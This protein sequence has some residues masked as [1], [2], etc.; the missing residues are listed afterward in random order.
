VHNSY[1]Q[2]G[3]EDAVVDAETA[4][5]R[6]NG[7][8]VIEYRRSNHELTGMNRAEAAASTLWAQRSAAELG[9]LIAQ[10]R[11]DVMHVHNTF[12]LISPAAYWTAH[13]FGVAVV[14]TVHNY[15]LICPQ[16]ML[17]RDGRI[18]EDCVG[19]LPWR[20]AWR[21]CYRDSRL[22]SS[23][24]AAMLTLHRSLGTYRRRVD[25]YI[26]LTEFGR[27]KLVAGGLPADRI[28]VKPNFV[29]APAA[30]LAS[31]HQKHFL[32]VGR[33][34]PEKG[35]TTLRDALGIHPDI[36]VRI[37]GDGPEAAELS[38]L[39]NAI[40]LGWLN[41]SAVDRQMQEAFAL[42]M[43]SICLETFGL[44]AIEAYAHGLPVIGSRLGA[45][46]TIIEDNNTGLLFDPG[47]P[48][49]LA[50]KLRWAVDHPEAMATMGRNARAAYE[51]HYSP[52]A[53]Y[54]KLVDIYD[55][56]ILARQGGNA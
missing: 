32:F 15:R 2:A 25:R 39:P 47:N 24:L 46:A 5:L 16:G 1:Q 4:L 49:D 37:A 56:A 27:D 20:G 35:I 45:L 22:Q 26:A 14:Q 7:H 18:C 42:L 40:Q 34:S 28:R 13:R 10:E 36:D 53:N 9:A 54:R 29:A 23:V 3:G 43:P 38:A 21:G 8:S 11:P 17:L 33:L 52:E 44:V 31:R 41:G 48:D 12:P 51:T 50:K 55:E 19:K 6:D 30:S